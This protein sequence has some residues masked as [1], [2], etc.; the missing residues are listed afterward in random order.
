MVTIL[1]TTISCKRKTVPIIHTY[2]V[3]LFLSCDNLTI[4]HGPNISHHPVKRKRGNRMPGKKISRKLLALRLSWSSQIKS[5]PAY[6]FIQ[7]MENSNNRLF[8]FPPCWQCNLNLSQPV[9]LASVL[10]MSYLDW[11]R[12]TETG[13]T[14]MDWA[15]PSK[16]TW[17]FPKVQQQLKTKLVKRFNLLLL[18]P[19][20]LCI[21]TKRMWSL[22]V[23]FF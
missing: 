1:N 2:L 23:D 17:N 8:D 5:N 14:K 16:L 15:Q 22:N 13:A 19:V 11:T 18:F 6:I 20:L 4:W 3:I 12:N 7:Q 9:H 10:I 21:E